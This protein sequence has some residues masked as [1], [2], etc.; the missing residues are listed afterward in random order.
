MLLCHSKILAGESMW[1]FYMSFEDGLIATLLSGTKGRMKKL[2]KSF[3][4]SEE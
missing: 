3:G 4:E 1:D 2:P